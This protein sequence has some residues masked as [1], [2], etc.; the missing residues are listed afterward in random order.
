MKFLT[1]AALSLL[2]V[3]D[4]A[5]R[6]AVIEIGSGGAVRRTNSEVSE[7]STNGVL[8]FWGAL[9]SPGR[10]LQHAGMT[11]VPDIFNRPADGIVVGIS[12]VD[13]DSMPT[14]NNL[15]VDEGV[16]GVVGHMEVEGEVESEMLSKLD[17]VEKL[18]SADAL[19]AA[20]KHHCQKAG[21]SGVQLE[22]N[23][24]N[25]AA[26]DSSVA[27][28]L[29]EL[30]SIADGSQTIIVHLVIEEDEGSAR[31]R[32]L[33]RRLNEDNNEEGNDNNGQE[34]NNDN[35][36][37]ENQG[38]Y[39]NGNGN[40][41]NYYANLKKNYYKYGYYNN[42]NEWVSQYKTMFQIQYFN[43]V[44]WTS[45]GLAVVL[46]ATISMLIN[47]PLMEDTLLFGQ[48]AKMSMDE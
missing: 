2:S 17:T 5:T 3:A 28:M 35:R 11:V 12:N 44:L 43:V 40:D 23:S 37:E 39:N 8:S 18:E 41:N 42:A 31:R 22:A 4:A 24:Q 6:V 20:A 27:S 21:I 48:S 7:T 36:D 34:N 32:H 47:M 1:A 16:N 25:A 29:E 46:I 19:P 45:L 33:A 15:M 26:I 9:H 38:N 13:L 10:K 30:R 14:V